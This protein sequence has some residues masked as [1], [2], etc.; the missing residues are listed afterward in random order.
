MIYNEFQY[1]DV[2]GDFSP[3]F[4][5]PPALS[6]L[7]SDHLLAPTALL[8]RGLGGRRRGL[9]RTAAEHRTED[10]PDDGADDADR[11]ELLPLL[12]RQ[13]LKQTA[14]PDASL[15]RRLGLLDRRESLG[16][17]Y[18]LPAPVVEAGPF[19]TL[20]DQLVLHEP[21]FAEEVEKHRL[22]PAEEFVRRVDF[23]LEDGDGL[24]GDA[25][26]YSASLGLVQNLPAHGAQKVDG[27]AHLVVRLQNLLLDV[28]RDCD[29][30]P[31]DESHRLL[32]A[33]R[34]E[35]EHDSLGRDLL[36]LAQRAVLL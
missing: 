14:T 1:A 29:A 26:G 7:G 20:T 35:G 31:L 28:L 8:L 3:I 34:R 25:E 16:R 24:D 17:G 30:E 32:P 11:A 23:I 33:A 18:W 9:G 21:G 19:G 27:L 6:L 2:Q 22:G 10:E 13:I 36:L 5:R 12:L 15:L 4:R